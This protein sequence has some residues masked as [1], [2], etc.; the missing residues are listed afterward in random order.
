MNNDNN[1][2][3][4]HSKLSRNTNAIRVDGIADHLVRKFGAPKSRNFFCKC[5]WHLSEDEIWTIYERAHAKGIKN[6]LGYFIRVCSIKMSD[7]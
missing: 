4:V 7:K 1:D 6:P 2:N 3:N 5:A